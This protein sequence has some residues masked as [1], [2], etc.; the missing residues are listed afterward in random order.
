MWAKISLQFSLQFNCWL[1]ERQA[2]MTACIIIFIL[3]SLTIISPI[4]GFNSLNWLPR[5]SPQQSF[6]TSSTLYLQ[7]EDLNE[8]RRKLLLSPFL[9]PLSLSP[10]SFAATSTTAPPLDLETMLLSVPTF[11]VT[12]SSGTPYMVVDEK[13]KI[14]A[15]FF[16]SAVEAERIIANGKEV[17]MGGERSGGVK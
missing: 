8:A 7:N 16:T 3:S 14:I 2:I 10:P 1:Q 15:Y 17:R 4:C 5:Q 13:A 9:L 12:D 11:A 6:S